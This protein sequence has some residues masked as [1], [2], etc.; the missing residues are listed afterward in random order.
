MNPGERHT[1]TGRQSGDAREHNAS[2]APNRRLGD[3]AGRSQI[4]LPDLDDTA[5]WRRH[6]EEAA[7]RESRAERERE[8]NAGMVRGA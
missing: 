4:P 2:A 7:W 6:E 1:W 8:I 3:G 5:D